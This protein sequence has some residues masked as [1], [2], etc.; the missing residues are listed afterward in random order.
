MY[1]VNMSPTEKDMREKGIGLY[2]GTGSLRLFPHEKKERKFR[3]VYRR[4]LMLTG[5]FSVSVSGKVVC[6]MKG[7][8]K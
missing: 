5:Q 8:G 3:K 6:S 4:Y 7:T 2:F 1:C